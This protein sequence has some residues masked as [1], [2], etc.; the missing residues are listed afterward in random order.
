MTAC[1]GDAA[2]REAVFGRAEANAG[3]LGQ[4][5]GSIIGF[6]PLGLADGFIADDAPI[7][8]LDAAHPAIANLDPQI[9]R[10]LQEAAEDAAADGVTIFV[11]AGWRSARYQQSL[12]EDAIAQFGS[13]S[14]ARRWVNTPELSTH[15][16]GRAVDVGPM[17]AMSWLSQHGSDYGL[18]QAYANELW[19]YER[20]IEPGGTCPEQL[21]D[22]SS[23]PHHAI[24]SIPRDPG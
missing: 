23:S 11:T 24:H 7:S 5:D 20:S 19:H 17:D 6:E 1:S 8:L 10:A 22:A 13:E 2:L 12:L 15:V 4:A 18:C 21:R 9:R 14:E 16:S 3:P